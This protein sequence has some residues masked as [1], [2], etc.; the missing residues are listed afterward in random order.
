MNKILSSNSGERKELDKLIKAS[1]S[2]EFGISGLVKSESF[3]SSDT[4]P[5]FVAAAEL[6]T[7]M[8]RVLFYFY[9]HIFLLSNM[10]RGHIC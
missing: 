2:D 8:L 9:F 1:T 10:L 3:E 6:A 5:G 7:N 4:S